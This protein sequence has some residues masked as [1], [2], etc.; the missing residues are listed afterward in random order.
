MKKILSIIVAL[1]F[2]F[3]GGE[4]VQAAES[5]DDVDINDYEHEV[6]YEDEEITVGSFGNNEEIAEMLEN[7]PTSVASYDF[8]NNSD[9]DITPFSTGTGPGGV[10]RIDVA[11]SDNRTIFW[12]VT[13]ATNWPY[14]FEGAIELRYFSGFSRDALITGAGAIGSTASGYI[15]LNAHNGG[16][17]TLTGNAYDATF[18]RYAVVPYVTIPFAPSR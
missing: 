9:S 8:L 10:S 5:L 12:S 15:T 2:F 18:A 14:V 17:A 11:T 3:V 1:A 4:V 7:S 16:T 6:I 13:P